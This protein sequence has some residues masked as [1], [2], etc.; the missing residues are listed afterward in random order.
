[1]MVVASDD[2]ETMTAIGGCW[3]LPVVAG[4]CRWLPA[5][6]NYEVVENDGGCR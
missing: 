4:G 2:V 5:V 1:M 6:A 3:W